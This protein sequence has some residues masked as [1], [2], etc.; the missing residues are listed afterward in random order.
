[1][2]S[3]IRNTFFRFAR[4]FTHAHAVIVRA[5]NTPVSGKKSAAEDYLTKT[6]QR[7]ESAG[8]ALKANR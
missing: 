8:Q 4:A 1:M 3:R 5:R 6:F 7:G 2:W